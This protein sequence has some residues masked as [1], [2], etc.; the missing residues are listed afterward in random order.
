MNKITRSARLNPGSSQAWLTGSAASNSRARQISPAAD[1][2]QSHRLD[3]RP[4]KGVADQAGRPLHQHA[5]PGRQRQP[6]SSAVL[7]AWH[8]AQRHWIFAATSAPTPA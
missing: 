3:P 7:T 2:A 5:D 8:A 4:P 1:A 6:I